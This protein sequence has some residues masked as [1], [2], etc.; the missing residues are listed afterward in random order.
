M[1]IDAD[2]SGLN[3]VYREIA[4]IFGINLAVKFYENFRGQQVVY[5]V[6]LYSKD[7]IMKCILEEYDGTNSKELSLKYGYTENWLLYKIKNSKINE[8]KV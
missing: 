1:M 5:P 6:S 4:E 2:I 7:Y 8:N 3:D